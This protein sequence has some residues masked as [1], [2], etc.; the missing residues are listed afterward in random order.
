MI[1]KINQ[2]K[3]ITTYLFIICL[4][5]INWRC[6]S[7]LSLWC[8]VVAAR[9]TVFSNMLYLCKYEFFSFHLKK[10]NKMFYL[11]GKDKAQLLIE[12]TT[13]RKTRI[14][15]ITHTGKNLEGIALEIVKMKM[16]D[17]D[18]QEIEMKTGDISH[19][20]MTIKIEAIARETVG[21]KIEDIVH[22]TMKL[23][24]RDIAFARTKR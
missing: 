12:T 6:F 1:I 13:F 15:I 18:H 17:V 23:K 3:P 11:L 2:G 5:C 14:E 16:K 20:T 7:Q 22:A 9:E 4:V 10:V 21:M 24:T 19:A 8:T